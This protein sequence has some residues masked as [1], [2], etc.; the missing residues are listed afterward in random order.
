M[1]KGPTSV[2]SIRF[3]LLLF[4]P[5]PKCNCRCPRQPCNSSGSIANV[6]LIVMTSSLK[7]V[8]VFKPKMHEL[9]QLPL[10]PPPVRQY[11]G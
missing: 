8:F 2:R 9:L 6:R 1:P 4:E 10:R 11:S 7:F 3:S 5:P